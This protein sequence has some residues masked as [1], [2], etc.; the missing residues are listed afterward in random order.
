MPRLLWRATIIAHRYL[1]VAV[2]LLMLVWF[3][4]GI[5]MMY[6]PYPGLTPKQRLIPLGPIAW[7]SCCSLD[8]QTIAGD[9]P[10]RNAHI[11]SIA[12]EPEL[13]LT[14]EDRPLSISS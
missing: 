11:Q 7:A 13:Y 6:V 9:A 4:S 3:A 10:V 2:G 1:G 14:R 5:V 12:G 8:A